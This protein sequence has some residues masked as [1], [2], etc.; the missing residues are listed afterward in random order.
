MDRP[1]W[2]F[3]RVIA[4]RGGGRFAPENTLAA[5]RKGHELGYCAVEFDVM[6]SADGQPLLI[7]D[8]TLERTTNGRGL[9]AG[10]DLEA[11]EQLDAGAWFGPAWRGERLPSFRSAALL[12]RELG[13][14]A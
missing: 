6:L 1:R 11:L 12:C 10:L 8:E 13:L 2:P 7:H 4:H 14:W 9:V 3:P 5:L